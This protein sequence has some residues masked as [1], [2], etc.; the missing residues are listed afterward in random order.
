MRVRIAWRGTQ[1]KT[2]STAAVSYTHLDVYKRQLLTASRR[3]SAICTRPPISAISKRL[4]AFLPE[5]TEIYY[6]FQG[7]TNKKL[8]ISPDAGTI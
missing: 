6:K 4:K 7:S 3:W 2:G 1:T 8:E 5:N